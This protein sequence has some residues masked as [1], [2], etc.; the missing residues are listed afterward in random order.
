MLPLREISFW[1]HSLFTGA[2]SRL[3]A[4]QL[5]RPAR[6]TSQGQCQQQ[7]TLNISGEHPGQGRRWPGWVRALTRAT[8]GPGTTEARVG[9]G[10]DQSNTRARDAHQQPTVY[11]SAHHRRPLTAPVATTAAVPNTPPLPSLSPASLTATTLHHY[12]PNLSTIRLCPLVPP[13]CIVSTTVTTLH[14]TTPA[15]SST[16]TTLHTLHHYPT[17]SSVTTTSTA[18]LQPSHSHHPPHITQGSK[19]NKKGI[20][21]RPNHTNLNCLKWRQ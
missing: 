15:A 9:Q 10:S 13:P 8:S 12:Y 20:S 14:T 17:T 6:V 11:C 3:W 1:L 7:S 18:T 16:A 19:A 5:G 2:S 4:G 21:C